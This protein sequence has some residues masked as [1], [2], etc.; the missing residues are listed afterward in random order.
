M[1]RA[2]IGNRNAKDGKLKANWEGPYRVKHATEKGAYHL[3][4]LKGRELPRTLNV[5]D[6]RRYYSSIM[7]YL[8]FCNKGYSF[9]YNRFYP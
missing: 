7:M 1:R 9:S 6:L 5:A 3:E 8:R 4:T 2:S